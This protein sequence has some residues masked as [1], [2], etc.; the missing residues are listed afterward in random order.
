MYV[1]APPESI[2]RARLVQRDLDDPGYVMNAS[3]LWAWRPEV[4]EGFAALRAQLAAKSSLAPREL[5]VLACAA[6]GRL[7]D[8]YFALAWG[9]RLAAAADE[10]LAAAVL[11]GANCGAL[12]GREQA[13]SGWARAM[14]SDPEATAPCDVAELRGAGLTEREIFEATAF[15]G[16][17]I[18]FSAVNRAL[19]VQP[20]WQLVA[21]APHRVR[22]AVVFARAVALVRE[23]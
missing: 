20:D 16:F 14:A 21:H 1:N 13:L 2:A 4:G 17:G 3:R 9:T 11:Q 7:G 22:A 19:G 18:A 6:A 8:P 5:G 23:D 15:V 10:T 12:T